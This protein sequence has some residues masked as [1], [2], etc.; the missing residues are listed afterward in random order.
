MG[1]KRLITRTALAL[2]CMASVIL[3]AVS[4]WAYAPEGDLLKI[5]GYSPE[6]IQTSGTQRSRQEWREPSPP[7]MSPFR[8]YLHNIYRGN[9]TEGVD[10]FGSTIIREY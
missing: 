4:A 6:I 5:K 9:W 10:E 1:M 7:K 2:V 8:R 3:S